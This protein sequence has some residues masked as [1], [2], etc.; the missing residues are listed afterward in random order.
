MKKKITRIAIWT[1]VICFLGYT[2]YFLWSQSQPIPDKY[3]LVHPE[4]RTIVSKSVAT[5]QI[6]PR[7]KVSVKPRITGTL[8]QICVKNGDRVQAGDLIAVVKIIPDMTALNE[9][10]SSVQATKLRYDEASREADRV[11]SLYEKDVVSKEEYE[12]SQSNLSLAKENMLKAQ[13]AL[14]IVLYGSSKRSGD[15][16]TTKVTSTM[17][18][19]V[20]DLPLKEGASVV[21]TNTFSD[22]TTIA[23]V[24]DMEDMIFEGKIDETEV[25]KL[26][27]GSEV[28]ITLGS[29]RDR[30]I[31]GVLEEIATLGVK[32][33]GTIMFPLK[34]SVRLEDGESVVRAG[35]SANAEFVTATVENVLSVDETSVVFDKDKKYVYVLRSKEEDVE[36]QE[37]ERVEV[38]TGLSDGIYI[39]ILEGVTPDMVLRG[40]K[41]N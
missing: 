32:E 37:F 2:F 19:T 31:R 21:S 1:L 7:K 4:T 23:T 6:Q 15:V 36:A 39:Q 34:V 16:N 14:D 24:A 26:I 38:R 12:H 9:A 33:N 10:Q 20:I 11:K 41:L 25:E 17:T 29:N 18:G 27:V 13:A 35:Y 22:G 30:L 3:E 28:T 40:N 5:G 8:A